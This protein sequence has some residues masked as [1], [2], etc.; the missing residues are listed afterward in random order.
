MGCTC[1][2]KALNISTIV[3]KLQMLLALKSARLYYA[4]GGA[5]EVYCNRAVC[6]S[7]C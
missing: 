5:T 2:P 7:V 4:E 3:I 1:L 6:P